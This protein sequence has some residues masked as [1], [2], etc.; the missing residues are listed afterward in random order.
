MSEPHDYN[1]NSLDSQVS[2][3]ITRL[4]GQDVIL[5]AIH[6]QTKLTNGRVTKLEMSKIYFV[7]I[8][9]GV[10]GLTA[11]LWKLLFH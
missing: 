1:P 10:S 11:A 4:N 7:G 5:R 8:C 6:A 3:I 9:A 2:T